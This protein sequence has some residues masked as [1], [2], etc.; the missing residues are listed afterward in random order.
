MIYVYECCLIIFFFF[1]CYETKKPSISRAAV[2]CECYSV[3]VIYNE[4]PNTQHC[5]KLF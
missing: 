4:N 1:F 2:K 3:K 5:D